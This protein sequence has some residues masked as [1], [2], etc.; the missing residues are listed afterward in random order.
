MKPPFVKIKQ[1]LEDWLEAVDYGYLN[2]SEYTPS[3]FA[4]KFM[5]F[6]KMV[7]MDVPESHLTPP[8]HLAML[9]K[10]DCG[11]NY[12]VNL[13]FR[14]AAK[15]S[16]FLEYLVLYLAVFQDLPG[17]GFIDGMIY[18]SDSMENGVKNARKNVET[19]YNNSPFLQAWL[20]HAKFTDP[21][22]EFKNKN[23][24]V[25]AVKMYGA[26]TGIRGSKIWAKRPKLAV[27]D[28]LLSDDDARSPTVI[29]AVKA[30]VYA[31]VNH[32]LDPVHRKVIFNGTPFHKEDPIVEAVESGE[33]AV[34]VWPVCEKFPCTREEFQGAWPDRF[35]FDFIQEQYDLAVGA[36]K[37]NMFYQELMLKVSSEEERLVNENGIQYYSRKLLMEN[38]DAYNFYITTDF[39]TSENAKADDSVI[40]VWAYN[41][42]GDF[43]WVDGMA[44]R[45]SMDKNIDALFRFIRYNPQQVGV[46]T[47]GQQ[48]GFIPWIKREMLLRNVWF[49][50]SREGDSKHAGL[51]SVGTKLERFNLVVPWFNEGKFYFPEEM[52]DSPIVKKFVQQIRAATF[53]GIK[54]KDDCL[55]TVSMLGKMRTWRPTATVVGVRDEHGVFKDASSIVNPTGLNLTGMGNSPPS[56]QTSNMSSYIV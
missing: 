47:N 20:P 25:F 38:K 49:N 46:E 8:M 23:G 39:A 7:N 15:T 32:A 55:D 5:N 13:M 2:S 52:K 16:V 27:L 14:G 6:I 51:R 33:W 50:L 9:D 26:M 29:E 41:S 28:D 35:T 31:G 48:G 30:T 44:E 53:S 1:T 34:N 42:N 4:L 12:I 19:R 37:L 43:F 56:Y 3:V 22:I 10:I 17:I 45:Q 40:S 11:H 36:K 54:G 21:Y 24:G 18:V